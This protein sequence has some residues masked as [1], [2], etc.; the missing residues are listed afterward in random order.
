MF[1]ILHPNAENMRV[2]SLSK[3]QSVHFLIDLLSEV[4]LISQ[5]TRQS[6]KT[7]MEDHEK[8]AAELLEW[9]KSRQHSRYTITE[10]E[11]QKC[12][13]LT[14]KTEYAAAVVTIFY[15]EYTICELRVSDQKDENVFYLHFELNDLEHAKGLFH[16]MEECLLK[17][18]EDNTI[19][20]LL[21]CTCGL[22]TSFFTMK[23]NEAVEALSVKMDFE[24]VPY[25][26]L[27][28]TAPAKDVILIAPQ[29]GYQLKNARSILTDKIVL[30]IPAAIFSSYDVLGLINYVRDAMSEKEETA[31]PHAN[32]VAALAEAAG[33]VLLVSVINME[34]RTQ[35][36]YRVYDGKDVVMEN[37]IVK[38]TYQAD[39]IIDV[40]GSVIRLNDRIETICVISP[41]SFINGHL[42]YEKANIYDFDIR[43]DIEGKYGKKTIVLNDTDAIALGYSQKERNGGETAFYFL[44]TGEYCGNIG[45]A[46]N[47][48]IFGNAGHMGGMQLSGI[49]DILTF[50]KNPYALAR[51]PEGNIALAARYI[52][53]LITFTGCEHVAFYAKM[54][55]DEKELVEELSTIIRKEYLPEIVKVSSIRDYLYDGAL[56]YIDNRKDQ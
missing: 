47:G 17:Q 54:I 29:I 9:I 50:P 13:S 32:D 12:R 7:N 52:A 1:K 18:K 21:C 51:T 20:V 46:E 28:E 14:L 31:S 53:G 55:P 10:S 15:L 22:T 5:Y 45:M 25:D 30:D 33:S 24:A 27:Y 35:L 2:R 11:D 39:D 36:A 38:E 34:G 6:E 16:E 40:I 4:V 48:T 8:I 37:Q 3:C 26:K 49:T 42:T 44:P 43:A 23:L 56:Y 19:H 41:G